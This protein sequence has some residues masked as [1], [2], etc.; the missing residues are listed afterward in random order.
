MSTNDIHGVERGWKVKSSDDE[1][2]GTV[3]EASERHIL[4]KSGLISTTE[5]YLPS[6]SLAHVWPEQKEIGISLTSADIEAGDW[7]EPPDDGP[8]TEGAP[9]NEESDAD[10]A[11]AMRGDIGAKPQTPRDD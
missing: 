6:A 11:D 10:V 2:I 9:L 5:R 3:V 1:D 4:V 8:R 7:S